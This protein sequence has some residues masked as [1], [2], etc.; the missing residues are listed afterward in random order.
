M[1]FKTQ[2]FCEEKTVPNQWHGQH[3]WVTLKETC[4]LDRI[5]S[6][7]FFPFHCEGA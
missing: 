7:F 5:L 1:I 6:V 4:L 2:F 3:I